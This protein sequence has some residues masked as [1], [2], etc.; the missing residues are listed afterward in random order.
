MFPML[1]PNDPK[2]SRMLE[3]LYLIGAGIL[4]GLMLDRGVRQEIPVS[5]L[6][7]SILVLGVARILLEDSRVALLAIGAAQGVVALG[8]GIA[9]LVAG[10]IKAGLCLLVVFLCYLVWLATSRRRGSGPA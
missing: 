2:A 3:L 8:C 1:I 9:E 7:I 5:V 10:R 4:V 6:L